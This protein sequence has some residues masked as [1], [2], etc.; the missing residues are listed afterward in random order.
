MPTR[1]QLLQAGTV[2]GAALLVPAAYLARPALAD[3]VQ[4]GTLDPRSLPKYVNPL[5]ILPVMPVRSR[6]GGVDCYEIAAR[7]ISQRVLPSGYPATTVFAYGPIGGGPVGFRWPGATIEARVD[8]PVRVRW[9]NQLMTPSGKFLPHLLPVDP[10]LH[11]A[12]PPGGV[13]GRDSRPEFT[14]T[15]GPYRGPVPIVTHLHGA[16]V[17]DDSDGYPEA[18]Y[19]PPAGNIPR[20]YA[21]VGSFYERFRARAR[22]RFGVEWPAGSAVF[23]YGNDQRAT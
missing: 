8:R 12:N 7:Q 9:A 17:D 10:T 16:H 11:W 23:Q 15:P 18:W 6:S 2:S 13:P 1:R 19:L 21:T 3:P 4:G 14:K 5:A 20:G 22:A